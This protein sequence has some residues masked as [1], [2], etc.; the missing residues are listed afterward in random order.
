MVFFSTQLLLLLLL[1]ILGSLLLLVRSG[2]K[3]KLAPGPVGLPMLGETAPAGPAP[4][5]EPAKPRS[6]ARPRHAAPPWR[7]A[8][9]AQIA[10]RWGTQEEG[11]MITVVSFF[12]IKKP[13]FNR[14]VGESVT[15]EGVASRLLAGRTTGISNN[16]KPVHN[17]T[18]IL[19]PNL[20]WG[21]QSH[22][23]CWTQMIKRIEWK[24]M[25][26]VIKKNRACSK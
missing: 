10:H 16:V 1:P 9:W 13:R 4:A 26:A 17:T 24:E 14:P 15:S 20:Q 21:Y 11:M 18:K 22:R 23:F 7:D 25:F 12:L 5:P 2:R 3:G 8:W 19:C 6:A